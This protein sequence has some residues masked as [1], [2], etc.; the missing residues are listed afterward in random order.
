MSPASRAAKAHPRQRLPWGLGVV[1]LVVAMLGAASL[2]HVVPAAWSDAS[3]LAARNMVNA[4]QDTQPPRINLNEWAVART[5][6]EEGIAISPDS[7]HLRAEL[8]YVYAVRAQTLGRLS[9]Q[10]PLYS[11]QMGLL[12]LAIEQYRAACALRPTFPYTW[13]QLALAKHQRGQDDAELWT[14]FDQA[15]RYGFAEATLQPSLTDIA[16]MRWP[17]LSTER[18]QTMARMIAQ[19]K[20]ENKP[21]L[22][23]MVQQ[24]GVTLPD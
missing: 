11:M 7:A 20:P 18:R 5:R 1:L 13:A 12:D 15:L 23:D 4:W 16:L 8:G 21:L 3:T 22:L 9:D 19:A 6:L 10:H 2:W 24:A 14:A 17:A